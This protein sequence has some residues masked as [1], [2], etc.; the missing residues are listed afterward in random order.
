MLGFLILIFVHSLICI[1]GDIKYVD[2]YNI[3]VRFGEQCDVCLFTLNVD[4]SVRMKMSKD[5]EC[6]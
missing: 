3:F 6:E 2:I 5:G 1:Y 4:L